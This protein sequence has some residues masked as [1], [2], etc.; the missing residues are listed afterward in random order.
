MSIVSVASPRELQLL[1]WLEHDT[2]RFETY[3]AAHPDITDRIEQL[4]DS[5]HGPGLR[6]RISE[7]LSEA[8]SSP[9]DLA[10]RLTARIGHDRSTDPA[11]VLL[12]LLG[13]GPRTLGM[14]FMSPGAP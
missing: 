9:L 3:I 11:S 7:T 2:P 14:L 10:E 8:I 13:V 4:L 5:L 1:E 12:D 6:A